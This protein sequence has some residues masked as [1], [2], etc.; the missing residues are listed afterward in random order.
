MLKY[1][2]SG[3]FYQVALLSIGSMLITFQNILKD[4]G[5]NNNIN[6]INKTIE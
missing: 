5:N 1:N 2:E 3:F 4:L 6:N